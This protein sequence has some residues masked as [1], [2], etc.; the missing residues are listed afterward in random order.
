MRCCVVVRARRPLPPV[1]PLG[2]R[3]SSVGEFPRGVSLFVAA[4][5]TCGLARVRLLQPTHTPPRPP[6]EPRQSPE[7]CVQVES[8]LA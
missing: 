7:R 6:G 2:P 4:P 1:P 8:P 5:Y 3:T